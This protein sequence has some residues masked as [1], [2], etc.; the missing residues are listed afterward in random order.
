MD[1][2]KIWYN[3]GKEYEC[4]LFLLILDDLDNP[5]DQYK[6]SIGDETD[7]AVILYQA[8]RNRYPRL[9]TV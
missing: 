5:S 9:V 2:G 7:I 1:I 3:S 6:S 8:N 4:I